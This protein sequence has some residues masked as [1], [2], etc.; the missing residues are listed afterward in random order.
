MIPLYQPGNSPVHRLASGVKL[1]FLLTSATLLFFVPSL[2]IQAI[3]LLAVL[4]LYAV[5]ECRFT[6]A[7][8]QL[9]PLWLILLLLF[10]FG[11]AF[12]GWEVALTSVVRLIGLL[13]LANLV[14]LT[15]TLTAMIDTIT[16][17][18]S[19]LKMFGVNTGQLGFM[20][21]LT[22]RF[23]PLMMTGYNELREARYARGGS[24]G[25]LS[26]IV[27]FLIKSLKLSD[28]LAEAIDARGWP[29]VTSD[30]PSG[31]TDAASKPPSN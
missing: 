13:L 25:L 28:A 26:Q 22:I 23:I 20:L 19:P 2:V 11:L 29:P 17:A 31:S 14:T 30:T 6:L 7:I 15:T 12:N 9:R 8:R 3:F 5:A 4:A 1:L 10:L 24:S 21:S 16:R 18:L 27:P